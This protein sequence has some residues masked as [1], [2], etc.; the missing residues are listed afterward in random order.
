MRAIL[1]AGALALATPAS[2]DVILGASYDAPTDRY[3]HAALGDDIEW[4]ALILSVRGAEGTR[5]VR[6]ELPRSMV[7]EDT[8]PRLAD[9]DGDGEPEVI[10]VESDQDRG[11]RL[12]VWG[13]EGRIAATSFIG[14]RF[15]WLA[16]VGAADLDGDGRIEIAYV[17]RPH[18][19]KTLRIV[20]QDGDRLVPVASHPGLSNHRYGVPFIEGGIASCDA[21]PMIFT[22]DGAWQ[23]IVATRLVEGQLLSMPVA[24]YDGPE[25][26]AGFLSCD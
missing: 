6:M 25:S 20:R 7:F 18:L 14:T 13:P 24:P 22:A 23:Q 10:T 8:E 17:D 2:A 1:V 4:G 9:I 26:F 5:Q 11:A 3:P 21:G 19:A 12:A 16:P 15:R